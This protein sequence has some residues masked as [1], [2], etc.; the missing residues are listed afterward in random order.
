MPKTFTVEFNGP[1]FSAAS[2]AALRKI[3]F[4][5][6][7]EFK[8]S[9]GKIH[10]VGQVPVQHEFAVKKWVR[11]GDVTLINVNP[12]KKGVRA[13]DARKPRKRKN[14]ISEKT[15]HRLRK[16]SPNTFKKMTDEEIKRAVKVKKNPIK[17]YLLAVE[18]SGKKYFYNGRWFDSVKSKAYRFE[19]KQAAM[20]IQD[21]A[22]K[23]FPKNA[24][25]NFSIIPVNV[26][27]A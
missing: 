19:S 14:P 1:K 11:A 12:A 10:T 17:K 15:A 23:A 20:E 6:V 4:I 8:S 21:R 22:N 5:F 3:P 2:Q 7:R 18:S 13:F 26:I 9:S 27:A 25:I 24:P 16:A